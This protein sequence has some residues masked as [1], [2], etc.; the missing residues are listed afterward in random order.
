MV[1]RIVDSGY[2]RL[3]STLSAT[4]VYTISKMALLFAKPKLK[5]AFSSQLRTSI[6]KMFFRPNHVGPYSRNSILEND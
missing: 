1:G 2:E 5:I 6:L 4:S 3:S